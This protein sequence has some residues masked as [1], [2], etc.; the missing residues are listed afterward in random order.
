MVEARFVDIVTGV[1]V[2][3]AVN[4]VAD[5]PGYASTMT[6]TWEVTPTNDGTRVDPEMTTSL[7]HLR[8]GSR[9]RA[10]VVAGKP[11]RPRRTVN[12]SR[13]GDPGRTTRSCHPLTPRRG[14]RL[15][16]Q[17]IGLPGLRQAPCRWRDVGC[18]DGAA[19]LAPAV[20]GAGPAGM[21]RRRRVGRGGVS[22][23]GRQVGAVA[24]RFALGLGRPGVLQA[25]HR[26]RLI[27]LKVFELS[28]ELVRFGVPSVAVDPLMR[29]LHQLRGTADSRVVV[30][31]LRVLTSAEFEFGY[32]GGLDSLS[33]ARVV[34]D[35][36]FRYPGHP[37]PGMSP[38]RTS[39][40]VGESTDPGTVDTVGRLV[41]EYAALYTAIMGRRP[42]LTA[43]CYEA[44]IADAERGMGLRLPEELRALYRVIHDDVAE[45]GVLGRY[46]LMP[47]DK[48]VATYLAEP[49]GSGGWDDGLFTI[50]P[51]V[52]ESYPPG[53]GSA[54]LPQRLVGDDCDGQQRELLYR[55]P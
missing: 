13:D 45:N 51:V 53:R 19:L 24:R 17:G 31:E 21:A 23:L 11:R 48:V 26:G 42:Q 38:P 46:C 5:D 29:L 34:V 40:N 28:G 32:S 9:G 20:L 33:P 49:P 2:V 18:C 35:A 39:V 14:S 7:W 16:Q 15:R 44:E 50:E 47:L 41:E 54:G 30:A 43:G 3:Q 6:M 52:F 22:D 8:R 10:R 25:V 27:E 4:F 1:R 55:R 37:L 36:G 12:P